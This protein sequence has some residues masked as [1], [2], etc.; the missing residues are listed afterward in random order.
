MNGCGRHWLSPPNLVVR[1][2]GLGLAVAMTLAVGGS[3]SA[4]DRFSTPNFGSAAR[5]PNAFKTC[6]D[7]T[8]AL[9]A[10]ASC[11]EPARE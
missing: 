8:Y 11:F 9:C 7:Q 2:V 5:S 6:K 1:L 10:V 4:D 3:A